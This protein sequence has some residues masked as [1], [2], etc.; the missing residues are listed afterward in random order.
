M[1]RYLFAL[2]LIASYTLSAEEITI[3]PLHHRLPEQVLPTLE[4]LVSPGGSIVGAGNQLFVRTTPENLAELQTV[5][6]AIDKPLQRL[7][8]S[9]RQ[10]N[11]FR[12][13]ERG[14]SIQQG[15]I[16]LGDN[17]QIQLEGSVQNNQSQGNNQSSQ[18][19]QT[20]EGAAAQIY[21]GQSLPLAM[22]QIQRQ[23][24]QLVLA[25]TIQYVDVGTGFTALPRLVGDQVELNIS[26]LQQQLNGNQI[27]QAN[28]STIIRGPLGTWIPL[29][30]GEISSNQQQSGLAGSS[31]QRNT[32][33]QH[34]WLKVERLN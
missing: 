17:S 10:G 30:G 29:G 24:H 31:N 23:N 12:A 33:Q 3:L 19:V 11:D 1:L 26:P 28:L 25:D 2:L 9:V 21:L 27:E 20:V 5:L 6:A 18:Q 8:I 7:L 16:K 34:V 13:D 4:P 32:R 14:L 15:S 22:R